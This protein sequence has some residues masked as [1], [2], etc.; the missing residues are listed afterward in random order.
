MQ[1]A[2]MTRSPTCHPADRLYGP[3]VAA[4]HAGIWLIWPRPAILIT[5]L[6]IGLVVTAL[7]VIGTALYAPDH[8]SDR[9]FHLLPWT[10]KRQQ[11]SARIRPGQ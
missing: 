8:I 5:V 10:T 4:A 7:A 6:D 2:A 3:A 11:A 9:A 1:P